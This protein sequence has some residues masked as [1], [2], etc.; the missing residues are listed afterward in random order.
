MC[1]YYRDEAKQYYKMYS[2]VNDKYRKI[3]E[4]LSEYK[5]EKIITESEKYN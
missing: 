4:E 2:E 5:K 1:I 3:L